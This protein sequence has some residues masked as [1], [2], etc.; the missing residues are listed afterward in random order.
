MNTIVL[1]GFKTGKESIINLTIQ[2]LDLAI[3]KHSQVV[4]QSLKNATQ[5]PELVTYCTR[6]LTELYMCVPFC[7]IQASFH[8]FINFYISI[9]TV[10]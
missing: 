8:F 10:I 3:L 1:K 2:I 7:L 5:I 6:A 4:M 9:T